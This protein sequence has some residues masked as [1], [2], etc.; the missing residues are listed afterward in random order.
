ML[1]GGLQMGARFCMAHLMTHKSETLGFLSMALDLTSTQ[2]SYPLL[3]P[4]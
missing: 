3:I 2:T 1:C 4:R